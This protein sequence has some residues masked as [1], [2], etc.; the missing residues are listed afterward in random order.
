MRNLFRFAL[1]AGLVVSTGAC[2]TLD[3]AMVRVFGRSM[4]DQASFDPYENTRLP[5]D[6]SVAFSAGNLTLGPGDVNIGNPEQP[7]YIIPDFTVRN[8]ANPADPILNGLE[9]PVSADEASLERGQELYLR[10]CVVCHGPEGVGTGAY[11]LEKWPALAA[12]NLAG[13]TVQ[14]YSDG[15]IYG[16]I[17]VGRG[18]MPQ[19]GH[20]VSHF[21]R[22]N[23]VNYVRQLQA[24]YNESQG[25]AQADANAEN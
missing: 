11:V 21:D 10:N 13:E 22:W 3:D 15:Y 5:A 12:Y 8:T 14:G 18:S 1:L 6:G 19:Y 9:N 20:Q 24:E 16:M 25:D 4:R 2:N 23:I 7:D 17:R